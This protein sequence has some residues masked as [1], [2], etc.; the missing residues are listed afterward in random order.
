MQ[1]E[2][3]VKIKDCLESICSI[4]KRV[5]DA[6]IVSSGSDCYLTV[7]FKMDILDMMLYFCASSG[8]LSE[9]NADFINRLLNVETTAESYI[10]MI[11]D[12]NIYSTEYKKANLVSLQAIKP[13]DNLINEIYQDPVMPSIISIMESIAKTIINM[14]G[15]INEQI[16]QDYKVF[17]TNLK[18]NYMSQDNRD[19]AT[20]AINETILHNNTLK[21]YYL[22][23]KS[24]TKNQNMH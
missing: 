1:D 8:T 23:K 24:S 2:L 5:E 22:K 18:K 3:I 4:F 9:E 14:N 17:F 15:G 6:G 7:D 20:T 12:N 10:A 21:A 19:F 13:F 11:D 16:S